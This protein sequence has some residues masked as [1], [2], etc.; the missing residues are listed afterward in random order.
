MKF[1]LPIFC[2]LLFIGCGNS[3]QNSNTV[4]EDTR[5]IEP[6]KVEVPQNATIPETTEVSIPEPTA[7]TPIKSKAAEPVAVAQ[8]PK[9]KTAVK[10]VAAVDGKAL[11]LQKCASCHGAKGEKAAL[12]KSQIIADFSEGKTKDALKGY[13]AG[14]YGKEMKGLMQGQTKGL[15][16]EQIDALAHYIAAP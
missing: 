15:S 1:I 5:I 9:E 4:A 7:S 16:E 14:T 13:Q 11:F 2:S 10:T 12:G 6:K 3:S 8:K